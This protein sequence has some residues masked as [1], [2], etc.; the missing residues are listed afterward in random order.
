[1]VDG[2]EL[3]FW[4]CFHEYDNKFEYTINDISAIFWA[5]N[6]LLAKKMHSTF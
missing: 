3:P 1:M 2:I 5:N 6:M 4:V